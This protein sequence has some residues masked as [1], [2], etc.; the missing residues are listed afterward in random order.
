MTDEPD[1][2]ADPRVTVEPVGTDVLEQ[3]GPRRHR[4]GTA[5]AVA[6]AVTA[7]VAVWAIAGRGGA[8]QP[9]PAP[10]GTAMDIDYRDDAMRAVGV[11]PALSGQLPVAVW[12]APHVVPGLHVFGTG[13]SPLPAGDYDLRAA[14]FGPGFIG[15][16]VRTATSLDSVPVSCSDGT[17]AA[18][19][20]FRLEEP[21][22][23]QVTVDRLDDDGAQAGPVAVAVALSDPRSVAARAALGPPDEDMLYGGVGTAGDWQSWSFEGEA[24]AYRLTL[25]CVGGGGVLAT[26]R[27][28][29]ETDRLELAC[30]PE[31]A[32]LQLG[33]GTPW[34]GAID[35]SVLALA[36]EHGRAGFAFRVD[37]VS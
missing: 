12:T 9:Q 24:G 36:G 27:T 33:V 28:E 37:G 29:S 25:V 34:P 13:E 18:S 4:V 19:M 26:L 14:C 11:D 21:G 2:R 31:G 16:D 30:T 32:S 35:V 17:D 1:F 6:V 22:T 7:L 5:V 3:S 20:T 15:V 23:V 8:G 10:T